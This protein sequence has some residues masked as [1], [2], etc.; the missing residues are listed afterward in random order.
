M[1]V[2][3]QKK[4]EVKDPWLHGSMVSSYPAME[5]G[6][7]GSSL[8]TAL[9]AVRASPTAESSAEHLV[10][11]LPGALRAACSTA[12]AAIERC[13]AFTGGSEL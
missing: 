6:E 12:L 5:L 10:R 11:T 13:V 4:V 1:V 8:T 7:L 2:K 9:A 3:V